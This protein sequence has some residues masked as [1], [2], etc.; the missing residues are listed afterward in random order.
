MESTVKVYG[1]VQQL[2]EGKTAP[3][4]H[5]LIAD[6]WQ[7]LGKAPGGDEAFGNKFGQDS[8]PDLLFDQRHLVIRGE[9]T[10]S[11]L[12]LRSIACKAFRDF[13][14]SR[15]VAEVTPPLL[16]QTQVEGG[17]TLFDFNYYGEKVLY[18]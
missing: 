17:S 12:R 2:P 10:S 11:V 18:I 15:N 3:G 8:S 9:V 6:Y 4:G 5:E 1:T 16:V 7:V 13:F 14:H